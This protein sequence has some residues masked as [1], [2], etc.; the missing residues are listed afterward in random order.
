[1]DVVSWRNCLHRGSAVNDNQVRLEF[2]DFFRKT[3]RAIRVACGPAIFEPQIATLDPAKLAP[4]ASKASTRGPASGSFSPIPM[5]TPILAVG[6]DFCARAA[7][8]HAAN[9][10]IPVMKSRRRIAFAKAQD[11]AKFG[12]TSGEYSRK[13]R[14]AE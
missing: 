10:T 11:Y 3:L 5:M 2:D 6:L 4:P 8:G 7:R 13:L 1:M 12:C 14:S 9:P